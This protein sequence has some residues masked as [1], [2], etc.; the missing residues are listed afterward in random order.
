MRA[1]DLDFPAASQESQNL[2]GLGGHHR[3]PH[4]QQSFEQLY[5]G[6]YNL[7]TC[8]YKLGWFGAPTYLR[9]RLGIG[10]RA[11]RRK[12]RAWLPKTAAVPDNFQSR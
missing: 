12:P 5:A 6:P 7:S 8:F 2:C 10:V 4:H 11:R 1:T 3:L 9:A